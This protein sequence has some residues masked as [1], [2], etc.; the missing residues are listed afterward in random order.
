MKLTSQM[1]KDYAKKIGLDDVGIC[2]I[3]RFEG[4]PP[5]MNPKNYFPEAKTVIV[6]LQRITRGSYRGIE[7]GTCW[8]NYT[9]YSYGRLNGYFRPRLSHK[10]ACFIEDHG[11]EACLHFPGVSDRQPYRDAVEPGR[12]PPNVIPSI[13]YLAVGAGLGEMGWSKVFLSSKFG[14]RCRMGAIFTD[15][16]LEPDDLI[17]PG[18]ICTKCGACTRRCPGQAIPDVKSDKTVT[19]NIGG[20]DY[21][22][23]DVQMGRCT[24]THHGFNSTISPFLK[25]DFPNFE[26]DVCSSDV[27]EVE[28][29]KIC[30][31]LRVGNWFATPF[32]PTG[33]TIPEYPLIINVSDGYHSI[34]GARGCI[35]ACMNILEKTKRIENLFDTPFEHK[36]PWIM[37]YKRE[38][39]VGNGV[40]P[41]WENYWKEKGLE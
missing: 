27:S 14:P 4:A 10:L 2:P 35:R 29:Y 5:L 8:N 7:E 19:V 15:A 16:E 41:W 3:E 31:A 34:C 33:R 38:K 36:K 23:G 20:K 32:L 26:F 9:F 11:W 6:T 28:A 18:T 12:L 37:D 21:T 40:N 24:F 17:E 25:K 30:C 1:I 13:R 39:P 22:F